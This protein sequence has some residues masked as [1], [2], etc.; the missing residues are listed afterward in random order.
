MPSEGGTLEQL[1]EVVGHTDQVP[2]D[3]AVLEV[4]ARRVQVSEDDLLVVDGL[5]ACS[6]LAEDRNDLL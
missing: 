4:D 6:Q 5:E 1:L 2:L 3:D